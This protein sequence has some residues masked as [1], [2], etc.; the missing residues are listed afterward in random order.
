MFFLD[1]PYVSDFLQRSV[2]GLGLPVLRTPCSDAMIADPGVRLLDDAAFLAAAREACTLGASGRPGCAKFY[3]NSE[4]SVAWIGRHL[5]DTPLPGLIDT[6]KDKV[7]FRELL[8]DL[9]PDFFHRGVSLTEL[10]ELDVSGFPFPF[11]I[12]PAVGFF[13]LGV[14]LVRSPE[15]WPAVRA[16]IRTEV[17]GLN[18]NYPAAVV[19]A[20]RYIVEQCAEGDEYALDAYFDAEGRPVIVN[21]L[22]HVFSSDDDVGDRLYYTSPSVVRAHFDAFAELVAAIGERGGFRNFPMH[23]EV[24]VDPSGRVVPIEANPL[25]F[26]GWCVADLTWFAWGVNPYELYFRDQAPDWPSLLAAR[27]GRATVMVIAD[28]PADVDRAALK[29]IDYDKFARAFETAGATPLELRRID[30]REYPVF[31]FMF[32]EIPEDRLGDLDPIL[33]SDLREF[34]F[35]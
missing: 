26:A 27:E 4:N 1:K 31:A 19:G 23:L 35:T 9:Y 7:R 18:A 13:S 11:I 24:R 5:A 20:E 34:L 6:C 10:D 33:K 12:K 3:C 22:R 15:H 21:V 14:H 16:T 28:I 25:R 8:H 30:W 32:A 17:A 2:A 29:G